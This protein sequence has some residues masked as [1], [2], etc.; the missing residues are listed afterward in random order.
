MRNEPDYLSLPRLLRQAQE[1]GL[2]LNE[3]TLQ[4]YVKRGLVPR[5]QKNP[6]TG[7]DGRATYW[8]STVLKRLRRIFQLKQQGFKLE[9][10]RSALEGGAKPPLAEGPEADW[11]R[12][13]AY[14]FL[15]N[16]AR[17]Q[18]KA[19]A[20]PEG[21]AAWLEALRQEQLAGLTPLIGEEAAQHWVNQFYLELHP[22]E[23]ARSLEVFQAR[24]NE[25]G[26]PPRSWTSEV[27]AQ[28]RQ[29][30]AQYLLGRVAD[31]DY[32]AYLDSQKQLF[33][34]A[35][36]KVALLTDPASRCAVTALE[37]LLEL[38]DSLNEIAPG[39]SGEVGTRK[40]LTVYDQ[41]LERLR[42]AGE[43]ERQLRWL[44]Q[45]P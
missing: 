23:L 42:L 34:Q 15:K 8:P 25:R 38:L 5:G 26:A 17:P 10:I 44:Q 39:R 27:S 2:D 31:S 22:R 35:R 9:Q 29:V 37:Q 1:L 11:R 19:A 21:V 16:E 33:R 43:V 6:Y 12:E 3:R 20:R 36:G 13:V 24:W 45:F 4:Y 14:R 40:A 41:C 32:Q 30:T 7:A 28:M 18:P